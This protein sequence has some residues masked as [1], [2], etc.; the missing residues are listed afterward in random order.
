MLDVIVSSF[1]LY[2]VHYFWA[3]AIVIFLYSFYVDYFKVVKIQ[4]HM[5]DEEFN[6]RVSELVRLGKIKL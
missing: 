1:K 5:S 4:D 3:M 6:F 2:F